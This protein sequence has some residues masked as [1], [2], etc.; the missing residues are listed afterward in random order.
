MGVRISSAIIL[1]KLGCLEL[2]RH[3]DLKEIG[4]AIQIDISL[5]A[6]ALYGMDFLRQG[7]HL[8][9]DL[10]ITRL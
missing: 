7:L 5:G 10:T 8:N 3:N 4:Q 9:F 2:G 6:I 1:D